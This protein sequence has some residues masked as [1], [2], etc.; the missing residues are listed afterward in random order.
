MKE[1]IQI[2]AAGR[3]VLPK[4]LRDR[5]RLRGGDSLTLEVKGDAI[6]LRPARSALR[7]Q[8]VNGV[9]VLNGVV[10]RADVDL[11][12]EARETRMAEVTGNLGRLDEH[13]L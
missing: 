4:A 8:R 6:E 13:L 5:F 7:L 1:T 9:L 12:A 3:L 11:V 10:V 2:D